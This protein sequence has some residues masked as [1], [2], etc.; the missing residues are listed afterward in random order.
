MAGAADGSSTQ[1]S[2]CGVLFGRQPAEHRG[3]LIVLFRIFVLEELRPSAGEL[4]A[5]D[6]LAVSQVRGLSETVDQLVARV[7]PHLVT[8]GDPVSNGKG[9]Q[10]SFKGTCGW[11]PIGRLDRGIRLL[12]FCNTSPG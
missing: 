4:L 7:A 10:F 6:R 3:L 8:L 2:A 5:D 11:W 9:D 1:G 12:G